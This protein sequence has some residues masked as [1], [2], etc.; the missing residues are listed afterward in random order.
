MDIVSVV[1]SY[2]IA[3]KKNGSIYIGLCPFHDDRNT[4]NLVVYPHND[5]FHCFTCNE[6]GSLPWFIAKIEH[7][8]LSEVNKK[9]AKMILKHKINKIGKNNLLNYKDELL[10]NLAT[11]VRNFLKKNPLLLNEALI[12]MR[13][14]DALVLKQEVIDRNTTRGLVDTLVFNLKKLTEEVKA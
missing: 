12:T 9:Y 5:T 11:V 6:N 4:P 13:D 14:V 1:K 8:P 2:G 3:L 7:I 10:K